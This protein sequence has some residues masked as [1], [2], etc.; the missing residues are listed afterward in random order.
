MVSGEN[1]KTITIVLILIE[2]LPYAGYSAKL[3]LN[4]FPYLEIV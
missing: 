4:L 3:A 2:G 1:D